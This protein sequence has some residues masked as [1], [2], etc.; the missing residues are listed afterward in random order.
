MNRRRH[1]LFAVLSLSL[2]LTACGNKGD[3]AVQF[4]NEGLIPEA[5]LPADLGLVVS[6]STRDAEQFSAVESMGKA[7]G[8]EDR[9]SRTASETLDTKLGDVGLDFEEDL[10]PALGDQFRMIYGVRPVKDGDPE[11][12]AVVTLEEPSK[13]TD[14]LSKLADEDQLSFKKLSELDAYIK[15]DSGLYMAVKDDLLL[16]ASSGENL[17]TMSEMEEDS[18]L[19]GSEAYQDTLE[20]IGP[21]YLLYGVMYPSVYTDDLSLPAGFSV[22]NIPEVVDQQVMVVRAEADGLAFD[23]W[24]N[25]DK[26]KAKEAEIAFDAVPRSEPYLF[27]E[28]SSDG[29]V[30]Y[31][32]S[33]GL[34]Q[35]FEEA[36]KLGDD[37]ASLEKAEQFTQSYFGMDFEDLMSFMD[38]GYALV[39]HKNSGVIPGITLYF[40]VSSDKENA[41][42][43]IDKV[44]SQLGG[45]LLIAQSAMPGAITKDTTT[46]GDAEF[47]R[48]K[49][50]LT[51][52]ASAESP[53]PSGLTANAI[54]LVYGLDDDR[55]VISLAN[56]WDSEGEMIDQSELYKNLSAKITEQ[57]EGLILVDARGLADLFKQFQSLQGSTPTSTEQAENVEKFLEGFLG[58]MAQSKTDKYESHF[59]GFLMLAD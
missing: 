17:V 25:A 8:D 29:L 48:I 21:N 59:G 26:Q 57:D 53:L 32:E 13:M 55:M 30:A 52:L 49:V 27:K 15:E 34:A 18:S 24:V 56:N 20:S 5:Y 58:A 1:I 35:T 38:K 6:Y 45:L 28:V 41:Q 40:D 42:A 33:Y 19:W 54:E 11:N 47:A 7:L 31:Y 44:D 4:S 22:S 43:F 50:D 51:S 23:A 3:L 10:K 39:V 16:V 2:L 37:T 14:V 12:F 9:V 46:W 36:R